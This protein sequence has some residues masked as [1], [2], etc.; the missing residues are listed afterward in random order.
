MFT[1]VVIIVVMLIILVSLGS[2][3]FF[4]V[5]DSGSTNRTVKALTLRIGISILLFLFLIL[6]FALGW[7]TP[8]T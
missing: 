2:G 7:L 5:K 8:N 4:L 6:G 1:K 3:L